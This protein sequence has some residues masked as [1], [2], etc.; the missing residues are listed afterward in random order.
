MP[1]RA[2][3]GAGTPAP[4]RGGV[5]ELP[6]PLLLLPFAA[7]ALAW[8]GYPWLARRVERP[9]LLRWLPPGLIVLGGALLWLAAT[10]APA[11]GHDA[12]PT[13]FAATAVALCDA[14]RALPDDRE[15]A[16][17][18]FQDRA[19][20]PLHSLAAD[21]ALDRALAADLL[22]AKERVE[23]AI[24]AGEPGV[25]LQPPMDALA[26]STGLAL[27]DIG[28]EVEPCDG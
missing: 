20:D 17:R 19:H 11:G 2:R 18:A 28:L 14:R 26:A 10:D 16:V 13:S 24:A 6:L 7:A 21:T 1:S 27:A 5:I 25:A 3:P 4:T 22:R 23:A 15:A 9:D 12:S 8:I